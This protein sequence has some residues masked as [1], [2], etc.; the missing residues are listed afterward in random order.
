MEIEEGVTASTDNTLRDLHNSSYDTKAEFNNCF[1]VHSK[2]I[3]SLKTKLKHGVTKARVRVTPRVRVRV[4]V[5][6]GGGGRV[7]LIACVAQ[8]F[9]RA[10]RTSGEAAGS[11][12]H[13]RSREKNKNCSRPNLRAVF[14]PSPIFIT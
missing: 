7:S 13:A 14:M 10:G 6:R 11:E 3:P 5:R 8:R 4:V 12:I 1:I 2:I 9:C